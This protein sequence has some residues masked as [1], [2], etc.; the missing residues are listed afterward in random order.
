MKYR[1]IRSIR[2]DNDV[3]QQQMAELLNVS[4]NTYSQY[5]TG[6]IEWTASTLIKIADYFDVSVDYLLDRTKNKKI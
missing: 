1:N 3:T 5:E 2:E 4:Q 6:K